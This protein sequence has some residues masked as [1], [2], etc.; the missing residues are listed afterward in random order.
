VVTRSLWEEEVVDGSPLE[1]VVAGGGGTGQRD[2]KK[3]RRPF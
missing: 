2:P 3:T 1:E